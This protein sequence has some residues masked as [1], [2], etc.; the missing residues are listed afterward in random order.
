MHGRD[1]G[2]THENRFAAEDQLFRQI[3][4]RCRQNF[5]RE[6]FI[7]PYRLWLTV[8]CRGNG[9]R[10]SGFKELFDPLQ[11]RTRLLRESFAQHQHAFRARHCDIEQPLLFFILL[12]FFPFFRFENE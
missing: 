6:S 1:I 12:V 9:A 5:H 2:F 10:L 7:E 4:L 11:P 8:P 3:E